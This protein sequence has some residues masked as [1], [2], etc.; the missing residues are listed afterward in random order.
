[1]LLGGKLVD[2]D[3]FIAKHLPLLLITDVQYIKVTLRIYI[4]TFFILFNI[5]KLDLNMAGF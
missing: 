2:S 3:T 4:Q 1:M 5:S